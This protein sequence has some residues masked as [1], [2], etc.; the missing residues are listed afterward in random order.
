M[1]KM[2]GGSQRIIAGHP[3]CIGRESVHSLTVG[4][5]V[6][7]PPCRHMNVPA[8]LVVHLQIGVYLLFLP[9]LPFLKVKKLIDE[10]QDSAST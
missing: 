4:V 8:P 7:K 6:K 9:V 5:H 3:N 2:K 1:N 10:S